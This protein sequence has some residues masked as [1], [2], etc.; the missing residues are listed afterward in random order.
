LIAT[1][2]STL[3][4]HWRRKPGQLATLVVGLSLATA[5]WTSVQAINAEARAS[6]D[7]ASAVLGGGALIVLTA[8]EGR[9]PVDRWAALRRD[10]WAASP[11]IEGSLLVGTQSFTLTGID[12]LSAAGGPGAA[13]PTNA[14]VG[15][16][17]LTQPGVLLAAPETAEALAASDLE[18]PPAQASAEIARGEILTDI[19]VAARLLGRGDTVDAILID[20]AARPGRTPLA[21]IV[22]ELELSQGDAGG[23]VARLTGSFHLNLT[24]FGLLSFAVG[25]FIVYAAVGLG[26]E[27]R[28]A[29]FRTLRAL[30]TPVSA[31]IT[32]LLAEVLALAL[33]AGAAG[34]VLGYGVA[35]ALL[36]DVAAT[37]RGLYGADVS[38]ALSVRPEWWVSGFAIAIL[39]ALGA[40]AQSLIRAANLPLLA[41]AQP[42]AWAIAS[43]RRYALQG[44]AALA[45]FLAAAIIPS[46]FSGVVAGF[47]LLASLLFG[48]ALALPPVLALSLNLAQ[49]LT[50]GP[51]A[52]WFMADTRQQLPGLSMALMALM[53]ALAAN[54]GVGTMVS[55]FRLT[56]EGWLDQR[57]AAELYIT[58]RDEAQSQ[59]VRAYLEPRTDAVLPIWSA[60]SEIAGRPG[61]VF[62]VV[63]HATYRDHWPL[64]VSQTGAWDAVTTGDGVL[65]NEQTW[66][67]LGLPLGAPVDIGAGPPLRLVGVYTDYGNPNA[68]AIIGIEALTDRYGAAVSRLR[69]GVRIAPEAAPALADAIQAEFDLPA[70]GVI[71]QASVKR[72]SLSVFER[73]FAVTGALNVLTLS[74]AAFAMF[75]SLTTLATMRLPQLAPV[76]ALGLTRKR[77]A[78]LELVR[79]VVLAVLTW[80]VAMPA[81]LLLAW[82]LLAVV[83]VEAFGW[84]LPM[85]LFPADWVRLAALAVLAALAAAALPARALARRSPRA[86]L[87]TFAQER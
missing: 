52:E 21:R 19:A 44:V 20:P 33:L 77:L 65:V 29:T 63:D 8:P 17:F 26:F 83:N 32:A 46:V 51:V 80:L 45:L 87:Q 25:L 9:I 11:I 40:T 76:W 30:G 60:D 84:R 13:T 23:E 34:V 64:L 67:G 24:A 47:A 50:R 48:A 16:D 42:R 39:G 54:I 81:G 61:E 5:L 10:G 28:R 15:I 75:A 74:V 55:S 59:A 1:V 31:I 85:H 79:A 82:A 27:Q 35:S 36:P 53:L 7:Q 18:L 71:D 62:G 58:T 86:F 38:G 2:L 56:F 14:A 49:R 72:F 70:N 37:L 41:S 69:Y 68:Q 73:T 4:S 6:Y 12:P 3:L 66:R 78:Q 43:T 57:L 22:P